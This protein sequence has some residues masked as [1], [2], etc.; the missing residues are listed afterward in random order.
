M[1]SGK[2]DNAVNQYYLQIQ[3]LSADQHTETSQPQP[4]PDSPPSNYTLTAIYI[5]IGMVIIG[6]LGLLFTKTRQLNK[7]IAVLVVSLITSA[8]PLGLNLTKQ[9]ATITSQA[10]PELTP[11]QI[12]VKNVSTS[13]FSIDWSTDKQQTGIIRLSTSEDMTQ[14]P[15]IVS[16]T[17]KEST[18]N[19]QVSVTGLKPGTNYF[20]EVLSGS[21]W[22]NHQGK[23]IPI[24]TSLE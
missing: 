5:F 6:T 3:A 14:N 16:S 18:S 13:G 7:L 12:I 9:T 24:T 22:Y 11:K 4:L 1:D 21:E 20:I 17:L 10:G 23:P 15:K 19:H 8:I 2:S